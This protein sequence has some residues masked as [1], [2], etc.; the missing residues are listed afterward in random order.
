V[1]LPTQ[2]LLVADAGPLIILAKCNHLELLTALFSQLHLPRAVVEESLMGGI[3]PEIPLL[4]EFIKRAKVHESIQ[5][6]WVND[7]RVELHEGEIQAMA[8][9]KKLDAL[10]LMDEAHGR[11]IAADNKVAVIGTLGVLIRAKY[12]GLIPTIQPVI[13]Q[14]RNH[15]YTI[16]ES[17]LALALRQ[18]GELSEG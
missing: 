6:E 14:M 8:L 4:R 10:V 11:R 1:Q 13:E 18:A 17:I 15:G 12:R 7:L 3:W 9:A 5:D 2:G 16:S